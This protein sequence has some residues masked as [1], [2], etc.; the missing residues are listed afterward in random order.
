M[1]LRLIERD[2]ARS[3]LSAN[4]NDMN[5]EVTTSARRA[6]ELLPNGVV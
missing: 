1:Y 4:E 3:V 2:C 6:F 5:L